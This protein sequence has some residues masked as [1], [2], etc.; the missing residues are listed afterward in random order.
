MGLWLLLVYCPLSHMLHHPRGFLNKAGVLD[1][2][3]G[4]TVHIAPG[5]AAFVCANLIGNRVDEAVER[6]E[7]RNLLLSVWGACFLWIGW[8]GF[9][10]GSSVIAATT[11][12]SETI[13]MTMIGATSAAI[14]WTGI[15]WSMTGHPSIL[16]MLSGAISGLI[17]LS[18]A[19]GYVDQTG[20]FIIGLI[21]G[22]ICY[23]ASDFRDFL[24]VKFE[25]LMGTFTLNFIGGVV[26]SFLLGFFANN[27][28][29]FFKYSN[30]AFYGHPEQIYLQIYGIVITTLWSGIVT[31]IIYF[32][33][34]YF[35][36]GLRVHKI[37]EE[38]GLDIAQLGVTMVALPKKQI[39]KLIE[40]C[41]AVLKEDKFDNDD[42]D[43]N[44]HGQ[45]DIH[46]NTILM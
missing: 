37:H 19:V 41:D 24:K 28:D 32:V 16:G 35:A 33:V 8:F 39:D 43:L 14:S 6:F 45:D 31:A 46:R 44:N 5:I 26:G 21:S 27:R 9:N 15:E 22:A 3:S 34:D 30:G 10:I 40:K 20:A 29:G 25:D 38:V 17:S 12:G 36:G 11:L 18:S 4:N 13:M 7:N 23:T 42:L 1:F 2:A